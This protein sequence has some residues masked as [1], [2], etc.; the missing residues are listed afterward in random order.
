ME[1]KEFKEFKENK[2]FKSIDDI[3]I[4]KSEYK[5]SKYTFKQLYDRIMSDKR[6]SITDLLRPLDKNGEIIPD[7]DIK[8][9][10]VNQYIQ[11]GHLFEAIF[12]LSFLLGVSKFGTVSMY[13]DNFDVKKEVVNIKDFMD[14]KV[15]CGS[16]D[17]VMDIKIFHMNCWY[18]FSS[19]F[20]KKEKS[21]EKYDIN[22]I[23]SVMKYQYPYI[24]DYKI[25]VCVHNK[26]QFKQK[27]QRARADQNKVVNYNTLDHELILDITDLQHYINRIRQIKNIDTFQLNTKHLKFH[28]HQTIIIRQFIQ[29]YTETLEQK[30][31]DLNFLIA[32]DPRTGKSYII[33]GIIYE[34]YNKFL[35]QNDKVKFNV[36]FFTSY[37]SETL[38]AICDIFKNY[39]EFED[40]TVSTSSQLLKIK[41]SKFSESKVCIHIVSKQYLQNRVGNNKFYSNYDYIV[42]DEAGDGI[43][44]KIVDNI[45]TEY[46]HEN[47]VKIF[48]TATPNKPALYFNVC[49]KHTYR[50]GLE[51]IVDMSKEKFN[52]LSRFTTLKSLNKDYLTFLAGE[53]IKKYYSQ[54]PKM[55]VMTTMFSE[56]PE[57]KDILDKCQERKVG[58]GML[59]IFKLKTINYKGI[60]S[61]VFENPEHVKQLLQII[62]GNSLSSTSK[63]HS[64]IGRI[65]SVIGHSFL[66]MIWFL[67]YFTENKTCDISNNL[68]ELIKE[69]KVL[70]KYEIVCLH[71]ITSKKD[72]T[73]TLINRANVAKANGKN[74]IILLTT[75]K[76]TFG[77]SLP[78]IDATI[79]LNHFESSDLLRQ[80]MWRSM[81]ES[82]HKIYGF[83]VDLNPKRIINSIVNISSKSGKSSVE[84]ITN[85]ISNVVEFDAD[86]IET[87]RIS[88]DKIIK[89]FNQ[90]LSEQLTSSNIYRL[91]R[92]LKDSIVFSDLNVSKLSIMELKKPKKT[93]VINIR[94]NISNGLDITRKKK[95]KDEEDV[96][97]DEEGEKDKK[98]EKKKEDT[99]N[100]IITKKRILGEMLLILV[101][102]L[103]AYNMNSNQRLMLIDFFDQLNEDDKLKKLINMKLLCSYKVPKLSVSLVNIINQIYEQ[104]NIILNNILDN[105]IEVSVLKLREIQM[106][107]EKIPNINQKEKLLEYINSLLIPSENEKVHNG[108]VFTP[109]NVINEM[110]DMLEQNYPDIF[111]NKKLKWLDSSNGIG[112]FTIC[113]YYRLMKNLTNKF[114][115]EDECSNHILTKMITVCEINPVNNAIYKKIMGNLDLKIYEQDFLEMK[116]E[117]KKKKRFDIIIGN[118][119]YHKISVKAKTTNMGLS[120]SIYTKFIEHSMK[121][122]DKVL[123]VTPSKWFFGCGKGTKFIKNMF[124]SQNI[125]QIKHFEN[126]KDIFKYVDIPGGVNYILID[127]K[128]KGDCNFNNITLDLTTLDAIYDNRFMDLVNRIKKTGCKYLTRYFK[129]RYFKIETNFENYKEDIEERDEK[130]SSGKYYKC[131]V[132]QDRGFIKHIHKK[133]ILDFI[134][135]KHFNRHKIIFTRTYGSHKAKTFG[136]IFIG[137]PQSLHSNTY[138][139]FSVKNEQIAKFLL[140][141]LQTKF[142]RVMLGLKKNTGDISEKTL[143]LIPV[144]KLNKLYTDKD[145][146]EYFELTDSEID[147]INTYCKEYNI[148]DDEKKTRK[149][150][151]KNK[152]EKDNKEFKYTIKIRT[153]N[154][155]KEYTYGDFNKLITPKKFTKDKLKNILKKYSINFLSKDNKQD[156]IDKL[157][158][159]M[160][161]N[162]IE[163]ED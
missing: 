19:K 139:S 154:G 25:G 13:I 76:A 29:D 117:K 100:D 115:S 118:P 146:N 34:L 135:D 95:N 65:R 120:T 14:S 11:S 109:L 161:E 69:D 138:H 59:S 153:E 54:F 93:W 58:F 89:I 151:V 156:L 124:E 35:L 51:D 70:K 87:R 125:K 64:I 26:E 40:F 98:D 82:T 129:S 43:C 71:R 38:N 6:E 78:F 103:I 144:P 163:I 92:K 4:L 41:N 140:S 121:L 101:N 111:K 149:T 12:K 130:I 50:W 8:D 102:T 134:D 96:E 28:L 114:K 17:G 15:N 113:L 20:F 150:K 162:V 32:C 147:L 105:Y 61:K 97:E 45:I 127:M 145:V 108:E 46:K 53:N 158:L 39:Q 18:L 132:N 131:Y 104:N 110:F 137:E 77:I 116:P 68:N 37:P 148:G 143:S 85:I 107:D 67:P 75:K 5:P 112:N 21:G 81:T 94:D 123:M 88:I 3:K 142:A 9:K 16:K 99:E 2:E 159:G 36:L 157:Y 86:L 80:M 160:K 33:A 63:K 141:Y 60:K 72:L 133:H 42:I 119:P 66:G 83:V 106:S 74:G 126:S 49:D 128:Y 55:Y 44:T 23:D 122:A 56:I 84:Y 52:R 73:L 10:T 57:Y 47:T 1:V 79:L 90:E 91:N 7:Q 152:E 155:I 136:N 24:K 22:S 48:I 62:S 30:Y 27:L 31:S